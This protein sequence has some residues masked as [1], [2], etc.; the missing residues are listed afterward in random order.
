MTL[1]KLSTIAIAGLV[2][3]SGIQV[4]RPARTN[5]PTD[6][7]R[8]LHARTAVPPDVAAI[9]DRA[10]RDC[11]SNETRWPWYSHV[12]PVSWWV[13]D[14][15]NHGRSH[16]NYSDWAKHDR[17]DARRLLENTCELARNG[18]MPLPSYL[19]MHRTARLTPGDV[20]AL[21]SWTTRSE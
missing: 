14:H 12:A 13:I 16:F 15:V 18:E 10:C 20:E 2:I 1:P 9:L 7:A 8:T 4:I 19:R 3:A 17:A 11:H 6:P 21:C 5:P